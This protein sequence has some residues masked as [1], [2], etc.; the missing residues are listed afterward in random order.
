MNDLK[1]IL[2]PKENKTNESIEIL[3]EKSDIKYII[4]LILKSKEDIYWIGSFE[5]ILSVIK[6]KD[7]YRLL[8]WKRLDGKTTAYAISDN[9]LLKYP[10]F[11]K[12]I[13][14]FRKMKILKEKIETPGIILAINK[15]IVFINIY[16]TKKIKVY[17]INDEYVF[18]IY[19]FLF[20][21]F[22]ESLK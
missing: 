20:F 6:E 2:I 16:K 13:G 4:S 7:L 19:K 18:S 10:T 9:T 17:I 11:S 3:E 12:E 22:W 8:T 14:N 15:K 1:K 21:S 5:S